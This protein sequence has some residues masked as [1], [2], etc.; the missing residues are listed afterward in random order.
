MLPPPRRRRR[1]LCRRVATQALLPPG[2]DIPGSFETVGHIAHL[3]LRDELLP[4]KLVI[5]RVLLDKNTPRIKTVLNKAR[6]RTRVSSTR[7]RSG[8]RPC[9]LSPDAAPAR[10]P[11]WHDRQRVPRARV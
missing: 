4:F 8:S 5:G 2:S 11:G 7:V 1:R 10:A 3:N 9:N 6:A